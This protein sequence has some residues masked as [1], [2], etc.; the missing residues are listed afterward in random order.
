MRRHIYATAALCLLGT[1]WYVSWVAVAPGPVAIGYLFMPLSM[2]TAGLAVRALRRAVPLAP[3][4]RR[5]WLLM[6]ICCYLQ[7]A[8]F[9]LL[10]V[11]AV[12]FAPEMPAMPPAG[13][14]LI[15]A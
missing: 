10:V 6:E 8:G 9:T 13:A 7:T 12:R 5:F 4:G 11:D 1:L 14:V 3:A 2:V 15:A